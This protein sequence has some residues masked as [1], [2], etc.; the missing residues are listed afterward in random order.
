MQKPHSFQFP[1]DSRLFYGLSEAK[2]L[3]RSST[4]N[5]TEPRSGREE[6]RTLRKR[7][8]LCPILC[9]T[10]GNLLNSNTA[11]PRNLIEIQISNSPLPAESDP[12]V[13]KIPSWF[14]CTS[15][16]GKNYPDQVPQPLSSF[17]W[18][19]CLWITLFLPPPGPSAVGCPSEWRCTKTQ[20]RN[21]DVWEI[22]R[23]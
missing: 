11:T 6:V 5:N 18:E 3:I 16:F 7:V 8:S 4:E 10:K 15:K 2:F 20:T 19:L 14:L 23:L 9:G 13:N 12:H 21:I 1:H 22:L 17:L